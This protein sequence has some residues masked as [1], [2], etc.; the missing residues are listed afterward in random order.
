MSEMFEDW[1]AQ[2]W[3]VDL[4]RWLQV[5]ANHKTLAYKARRWVIL[6]LS[7][8]GCNEP[9]LHLSLI[10]KHKSI[11]LIILLIRFSSSWAMPGHASNNRT[12]RCMVNSNSHSVGH[13]DWSK[14]SWANGEKCL[15]NPLHEQGQRV[16]YSKINNTLYTFTG[17]QAKWNDS[18]S[19]TLKH[20]LTWLGRGLCT[21]PKKCPCCHCQWVTETWKISSTFISHS[22]YQDGLQDIMFTRVICSR[23]EY[24][25]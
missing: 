8:T 10:V 15:K 17:N 9:F 7:G 19:W 3:S 16:L 5:M 18:C 2:T 20:S 22:V 23:S 1:A 21:K 4:V 24:D 25:E 14:R 12:I 11:F 13:K 6:M